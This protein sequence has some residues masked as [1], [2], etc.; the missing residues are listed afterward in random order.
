M[1]KKSLFISFIFVVFS[2]QTAFSQGLVNGTVVD[3]VDGRTLIVANSTGNK[4]NVRL[5]YLEIPEPEQPLFDVVKN[6]LK[7]LALGKKI[8]VTKVQIF[9]N[10]TLGVVLINE[11][12]AKFDLSQQMIRDGAG[13]FDVHDASAVTDESADDYKETQILA[14][15]EKR[16]VWSIPGMKT[17]WEHRD[18]KTAKNVT[19]VSSTSA[20]NT[21]KKAD[22]MSLAEMV[23]NSS[24]DTNG[25]GRLAIYDFEYKTAK[26]AVDSTA[27]TMTETKANGAGNEVSTDLNQVYNAQFGKGSVSTKAFEF[28]IQNG[29]TN[30]KLALLFGYNYSVQNSNKDISELGLLVLAKLEKL[31]FLKGKNVALMLDDGKKVRLGVGKYNSVKNVEGIL[32]QSLSRDEVLSI[33]ESNSVTVV[34]GKYKK[35]IPGSYKQT[36]DN[37]VATLK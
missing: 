33:L 4:I 2:L 22:D 5:R 17:P 9:S 35:Q 27:G 29:K 21:E 32:F 31:A 6:H 10:Y 36:I 23:K 1:L 11:R 16:G 12:A 19:T 7:D 26:P 13:W 18:E 24:K 28:T 34:I 25:F 8:Y 14:K 3:V 37:F 20:P 30:Q 15:N